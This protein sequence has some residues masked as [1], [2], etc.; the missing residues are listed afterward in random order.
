MINSITKEQQY[1][2]DEERRKRYRR[3]AHEI[4]RHYK[5]PLSEECHKSYGSEGSLNISNS[6][7]QSSM[8]INLHGEISPREEVV[9][10]AE[11]CV[12]MMIEI[13]KLKLRF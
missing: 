3:T 7:T 13:E 8:P 10:Q 4:A 1:L 11:V 9:V 5:C 12:L 6:N 2:M